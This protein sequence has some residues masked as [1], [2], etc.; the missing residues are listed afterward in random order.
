MPRPNKP[1]E[2][3]AEDHL[4][5]RIAAERD[6]R[7]WTNDGLAKRMT[8]AGCPMNGSAIFKI[9]KGE[10]RRRIVVDELVA[11]GTVFG[12]PVEQL[13]LPPEAAMSEQIVGLVLDWN[14]ARV[15]AVNAAQQARDKLDLLA[16]FARA[17]PEAESSVEQAIDVWATHVETSGEAGLLKAEVMHKITGSAEWESAASEAA[18]ELLKPKKRRGRG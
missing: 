3:Q 5:R 13:L 6:A 2:V 8:D 18:A 17:H 16:D 11:F 10:P 9:E 4:A 14:T 12:V 15:A 1:R 7:G